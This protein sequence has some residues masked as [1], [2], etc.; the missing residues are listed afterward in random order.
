MAVKRIT[1]RVPPEL[2]QRLVE[3]GNRQDRSLNHVAV[4]ALESYAEQQQEK[5][6]RFPLKEL[7]DL[8]APAVAAA[9]ITEEEL[10]AHVKEVRHQIWE[11]RYKQAVEAIR[12]Q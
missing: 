3:I 6:A 5:P 11:E 8:I 1:L 9:G 10:M 4:E 2:H 7:S 12:S